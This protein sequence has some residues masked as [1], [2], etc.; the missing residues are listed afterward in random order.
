MGEESVFT[1]LKG[2]LRNQAEKPDTERAAART[3]FGFLERVCKCFFQCCHHDEWMTTI[4]NFI[5]KKE[6]NFSERIFQW[7]SLTCMAIGRQGTFTD[8][9]TSEPNETVPKQCILQTFL[10]IQ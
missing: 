10:V 8:S 5:F 9:P 4:C 2:R 1:E 3:V 6:L 7:L